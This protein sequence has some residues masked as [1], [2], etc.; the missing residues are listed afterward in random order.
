MHESED[1]DRGRGGAVVETPGW[2]TLWKAVAFKEW[3][4]LRIPWAVLFTLSSGYAIYLCLRVRRLFVLHD[5]VAIWNTWI[6]KNFLFW[7]PFVFLPLV[8]AVIFGVWQFLPE[9][10]Q[11]RIRLVLHLPVNEDRMVLAHLLCGV[12]AL[13][14]LWLPAM[15]LFG[16][17]AFSF[18]PPEILGQ[19]FW[20][21]SPPLLAGLA[22]YLLVAS[23]HL[24]PSRRL[25]MAIL[26]LGAGSLPLFFQSVLPGGASRVLPALAIWTCGL[27][28]IPLMAARHFR[29]GSN[30]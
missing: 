11:Q 14:A 28:L 6:G 12:T 15:A 2:L 24:E 16:L 18:F 8:S 1:L 25:R 7:S 4:K 9:T 30:T 21:M 10:H 20:T 19:M 5:A 3:V 17:T 26:L 23:M 13:L 29:R 22:A 27:T